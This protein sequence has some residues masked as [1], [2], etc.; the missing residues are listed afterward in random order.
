FPPEIEASLPVY[1]PNC[2]GNYEPLFLG[3]QSGGTG[4]LEVDWNG[5]DADEVIPGEY[6]FSVTD[7]AAC[8]AVFELE[9]DPFD[10]LSVSSEI[11]GQ[12]DEQGG[13]I[14]LEPSGGFPPYE[15]LWATGEDSFTLNNLEAGSY[16]ALITDDLGCELS[17]ETLITSIDAALMFG[18]NLY[19][20]PGQDYFILEGLEGFDL[21]MVNMLGEKVLETSIHKGVQS[22]PS[23]NLAAG[24]YF[25][26]LRNASNLMV[27]PWVKE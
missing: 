4:S 9:L 10:V 5:L 18:V 7:E 24:R 11:L 22:I 23:K 3:V 13:S 1:V 2:N 25:L 17:F 27:F 20:N 16:M 8:E 26:H 19:P 15:I 14:L 12:S 6:S 21:M